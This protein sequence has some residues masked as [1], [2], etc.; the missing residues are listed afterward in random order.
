MKKWLATVVVV[1]AL[2][3]PAAQ[4]LDPITAE[5][6]L[7]VQT[8]N[9]LDLS[10]DGRC[11]A[12]GVRRLIRQRRDDHRRYGDPTY[13]AP[14]MVDLQVIDT[15]TGAADKRRQGIDERPP[16]RVHARWRQACD[17]DGRGDAGRPADRRRCGST[18]SSARRCRK[19]RARAARMWQPT[20]SWRGR[21][22]AR[23]LFVALRSPGGRSPRRR[24]RSR[25]WSPA[26]S[27]CSRRSRSSIGMR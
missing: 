25:R 24:R 21:P 15:R 6:M 4:S 22:T 10:E 3:S 11:V 9:V 1:S 18:T 17:T 16:G 20:P 2:S 23:R 26:R 14:T 13:F 8:A 19:C 27:S 7:K 5:D 12:I